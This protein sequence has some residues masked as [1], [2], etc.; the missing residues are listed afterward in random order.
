MNTMIASAQKN[1]AAY[2]G[3]PAVTGFPVC[4]RN[5]SVIVNANIF[6]MQ[7]IV[8]IRLKKLVLIL[9]L[10]LSGL[11]GI[12]ARAAVKE[13][14]ANPVIYSDYSDPDAIASHDGNG[15]YMTASSFHCTPGLPVLFS[16]DLVNWEI[17]N[18]ALEQVPP[19]E[20]YN[21]GPRHGKGVWA[22]SMR[23]HDGK[24]YIYWGDP[25]FGIFM[26]NATDPRGKWSEPVMVRSGKGMIDP[27]P[28]WDE[29]GKAYLAFAW[30]AS[31]SRF[32]S[33][34]C[35]WEMSADGTSLTGNPK[36]VFDG[37]ANGNH[38][39]EGPKLYKRD[40]MY[41]ILCPAGG[42]DKGWQLAM[43]SINIWG[44]YEH[45]IVLEQGG[46]DVNGPHQGALVDT[47]SGESWFLHFQ[48]KQ[49]WGRII[50]LNPVKWVDG[51]PVMGDNG[52]PVKKY[53]MPVKSHPEHQIACS[54]EFDN[55]SLGLQWQWHGNYSPE[56]GMP[57][58]DGK[59]RV[60]GY[61]TD[62]VP[63]LWNVPNLLLQKFHNPGFTATA[64]IMVTAR[65]DRQ[66]S[67]IVV[68]GRDYHRLAVQKQGDKFVIKD[69]VCHDAETA[70]AETVNEEKILTDAVAIE[71]GLN[72]NYSC[73]A[74]L[75]V[76]VLP[77][78]ACQFSYSLDGNKFIPA[79]DSF[80]AREGKWIGAKYG[81]Y[82]IA[83][84]SADRGWIDIDSFI[85][86]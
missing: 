76:K 28:F 71:A 10:M 8:K 4:A 3:C 51:W 82:S 57:I 1:H 42:V 67:G 34:L 9:A 52:T 84:A 41:Y 69:I 49:P 37:N 85:V 32:N 12:V 43:R 80:K 83:P 22:P 17:V 23:F 27:V 44:P 35:L 81:I 61:L 48:E 2:T 45:R 16:E 75:R 33:V 47:P 68:M 60:Y 62:S 11:Q 6:L 14:Y 40:G 5:I 70:K 58:A 72:P 55:G 13:T 56:F 79:G 74:W 73:K 15:Y 20:Y 53:K 46:T 36:I 77:D 31:R 38:T 63:N 65:D 26:V 59:M 19:A 25:D 78:G 54:D 30:A 7:N 24:Y 29:D 86:K 18:Y 21:A 64:E 66:Q 50:H 39:C